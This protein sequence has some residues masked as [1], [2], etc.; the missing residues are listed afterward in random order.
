MLK[1][2]HADA[3]YRNSPETEDY[4]EAGGYSVEQQISEN[5]REDQRGKLTRAI[6]KGRKQDDDPR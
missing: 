6:R 1:P 2:D 3:R 5:K 4:A